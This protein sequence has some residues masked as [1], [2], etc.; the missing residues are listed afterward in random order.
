M[1]NPYIPNLAVIRKITTENEVNDIKTFELVFQD[2]EAMKKF[3]YRCGQFAEIS[4]FGA[5]ECPLGIASSPM[6]E[7]YI[8]FT[9]KKVGVVT[10]ALHNC[11][12]GTVIG[13]RGPY[14]NGFPLERMEGRNVVIVGGGF[15]FTTLRSLTKFI[16]HE[17]NRDRFRGLTVIYGAR[18]PGE[19][20]YKYDLEAWGKRDDINLNVTIDRAVPG[21]TGL[22]GFV[23][24]VLKE[25]APSSENAI[26]IVCGP[27]IMIKFTMPVLNEL[28]FPPEEVFLSLEMRMKCG[29]GKCG[30]CNIGDKFVCKD[31]PVFAYKELAMMPKEY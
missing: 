21:W 16:L 27:P 23:P 7:G 15:A 31:G 22:V 6:D 3:K 4:V 19:L 9:I 26:A 29:I 11:E 18:N 24:A 28:G 1:S 2:P 12:E 14:G 13:V 30:R 17:V 10:T 5:G 8:Q 25:T 20:A